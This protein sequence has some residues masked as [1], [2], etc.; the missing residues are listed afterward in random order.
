[1]FAA[2]GRGTGL[3]VAL[4]GEADRAARTPVDR[5]E[6]GVDTPGRV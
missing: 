1:M 5:V 6:L 3:V 2:D 4:L